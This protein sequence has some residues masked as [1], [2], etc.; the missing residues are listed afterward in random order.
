MHPNLSKIEDVHYT[1]LCIVP[2][3]HGAILLRFERV[4]LPRDVHHLIQ[5]HHPAPKVYL[6]VGHYTYNFTIRTLLCFG[7]F[8]T[9]YN[10][11]RLL[12][13]YISLAYEY[14]VICSD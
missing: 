11:I 14:H 8:K 2:Q 7:F 1:A 13:I 12:Q 5:I 9:G 10:C 6:W 4:S 3:T